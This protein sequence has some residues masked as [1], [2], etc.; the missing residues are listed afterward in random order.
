MA[1][2][3]ITEHSDAF[4][5]GA[6]SRVLMPTSSVEEEKSSKWKEINPPYSA[7]RDRF[8]IHRRPVK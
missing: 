2:M 6:G 7:L 1:D 4:V 3:G 5:M 8:D